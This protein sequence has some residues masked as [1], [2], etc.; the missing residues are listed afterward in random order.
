MTELNREIGGHE[1]SSQPS[2]TPRRDHSCPNLM[3][4]LLFEKGLKRDIRGGGKE[5][6]EIE[7]E[8]HHRSLRE[9]V[10]IASTEDWISR[11]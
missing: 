6:H 11:L 9:K 10:K 5:R 2:T 8:K 7:R 3:G 1:A 4:F